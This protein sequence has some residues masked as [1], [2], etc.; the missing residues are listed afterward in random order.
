MAGAPPMLPSASQPS[1]LFYRT[2]PHPHQS[3]GSSTY[4]KPCPPSQPLT[5]LTIG[6]RPWASRNLPHKG[7]LFHKTRKIP[8]SSPHTEDHAP[9]PSQD[10]SGYFGRASLAPLQPLDHANWQR[11]RWIDCFEPGVAHEGEPSNAEESMVD[12][13]HVLRPVRDAPVLLILRKQ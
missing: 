11:I 9:C 10:P 8:R 4:Y 12:V 13:H 3:A 5:L 1:L 7:S 2:A 6:H